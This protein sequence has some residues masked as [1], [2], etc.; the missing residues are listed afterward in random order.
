MNMKL[1]AASWH[2]RFVRCVCSLLGAASVVACGAASREASDTVVEPSRPGIVGQGES[3]DF[4]GA[5]RSTCKAGLVCCY[6]P[7]GDP[8]PY[9]TCLPECEEET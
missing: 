4:G 8:N 2:M 6:G 1:L 7:E 3:C 9:G 5:E